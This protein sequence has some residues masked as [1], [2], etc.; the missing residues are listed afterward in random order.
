[1][2][3]LVKPGARKH[4]SWVGVAG[5]GGLESCTQTTGM[6]GYHWDTDD[7]RGHGTAA[8]DMW[9]WGIHGGYM[10]AVC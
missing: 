6:H 10:A 3:T 5:G 2:G 8:G 9:P 4:C 7:D 1:M